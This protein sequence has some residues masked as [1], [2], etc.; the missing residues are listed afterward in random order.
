MSVAS[1]LLVIAAAAVAWA[2]LRRTTA[3]PSW[4]D[5]S[6]PLLCLGGGLEEMFFGASN[7]AH[8]PVPMALVFALALA[9]TL[10]SPLPR[11]LLA[12]V[13]GLLCV[14]SGFGFFVGVEPRFLPSSRLGRVGGVQI[15]PAGARGLE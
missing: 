7:P 13:L 14:F 4:T 12:G 8:G 6:A 2:A 9:W 1:A 3:A 10:R 5:V 11:A 15:P